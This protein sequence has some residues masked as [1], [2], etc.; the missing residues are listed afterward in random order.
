MVS[1]Q[2]TFVI[3]IIITIITTIIA[4]IIIIT[5]DIILITTIKS[6][7]QIRKLCLKAVCIWLYHWY[8][9]ELVYC[10]NHCL[11]L[12]FNVNC[13]RI[14]IIWTHLYT[15]SEFSTESYP[16][17]AYKYMMKWMDYIWNHQE[18]HDR[19]D[20][21]KAELSRKKAEPEEEMGREG[22]LQGGEGSK[23]AF[24]H[25]AVVPEP[26]GQFLGAGWEGCGTWKA[27][28][29]SQE[30]LCTPQ[31]SWPWGPILQQ[32]IL[33]V[34]SPQVSTHLILSMLIKH[35]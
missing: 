1:A 23:A 27:G 19:S 10:V 35:V 17:E 28:L 13:F 26:L 25:S 29:G 4:D 16:E 33:L 34:W 12:H 9:M 8:N 2:Y 3:T 20:L 18:F 7:L 21:L 14:D 22:Y 24:V 6:I 30:A 5:I 15:C 32:M 11:T 31:G